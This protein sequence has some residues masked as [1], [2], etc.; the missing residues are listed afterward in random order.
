MV[1]CDWLIRLFESMAVNNILCSIYSCI[2][3][4]TLEEVFIFIFKCQIVS[5]LLLPSMLTC[6]CLLFEVSIT[7]LWVLEYWAGRGILQILYVIIFNWSLFNSS[8]FPLTSILPVFGIASNTWL[9]QTHLDYFIMCLLL[10]GFLNTSYFQQLGV[11]VGFG[12]TH[13]QKDKILVV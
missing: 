6:I 13:Q 10:L 3:S 5:L 1:I 12:L 11:Q 7:C 4:H 9:T 8:H 2:L